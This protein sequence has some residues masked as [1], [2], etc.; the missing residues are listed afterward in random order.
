MSPI[1]D[2]FLNLDLTI[3]E[4][5]YYNWIIHSLNDVNDITW[6]VRLRN[7][8]QVDPGWVAAGWF[9]P[10][11]PWPVDQRPL[12]D[13][14]P[15]PF[16]ACPP[17]EPPVGLAGKPGGGPLLGAHNSDELVSQVE[18]LFFPPPLFDVDPLPPPP[19]P[20]EFSF[21]L[22]Q[23]KKCLYKIKNKQNL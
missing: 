18:A 22:N 4:F 11:Q 9:G 12:L 7:N 8:N 15:Q 16:V 17:L 2:L 21:T 19:A 1:Y 23:F 20:L 13:N 3:E 6:G 5:K 10:G 14:G